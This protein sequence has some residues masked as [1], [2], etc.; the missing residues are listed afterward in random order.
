M[1]FTLRELQV[2][3]GRTH[4]IGKCVGRR[5]GVGRLAQDLQQA[6]PGVLRVVE[7]IPAFDEERV[8]AHLAR[9][10]SAALAHPRLDEGVTGLPE[11]GHAAV[12]ADPGREV[13]R[14]LYVVDD[15]GARLAREDVLREQH[16]LPVPKND[17]PLGG[18]HAQRASWPDSILLRKRWTSSPARVIPASTIFNPL[19]SGGL[20]LPVTATALPQASSCAA[21]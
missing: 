20:W 3:F 6:C 8:A 17:L 4:R 12:P 2:Q 14:A 1:R 9:E 11:A 19:Y 5:G 7:S 21:K 15:L 13:A 10:R 18:R 16:Q